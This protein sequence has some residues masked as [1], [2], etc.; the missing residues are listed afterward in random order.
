MGLFLALTL[1][2]ASTFVVAAQSRYTYTT[3]TVQKYLGIGTTSPKAPLQIDFGSTGRI[4]GGTPLGNGPGWTFTAANG[5]RRDLT[6]WNGGF[7]MGASYDSSAANSDL[8]LCEGGNMGIGYYDG[9][10]PN[11]L[12]IG[13]NV[14]T[15]PIANAWTT[16]SSREYKADIHGLSPA[17]YDEALQSVIDTRVVHF[18][19]NGEDPTAEPRLGVIAEES[20]GVILS[21]SDPKSVSLSEYISLLHAAIK[22][23]Q[24]QID[25]QEKEIDQLRVQVDRLL[26]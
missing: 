6:A 8:V 15:D 23:Q 10:P 21:Q 7:Y 12:T 4:V 18:R 11:I 16:Y 5:H 24:A 13:Q 25:A 3:L 14:W 19:Y 17:E 20:P 9:C 22:S 26:R 1:A 2:F